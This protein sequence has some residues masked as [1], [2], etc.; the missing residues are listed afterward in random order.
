M[1]WD[2]YEGSSGANLEDLGWYG[3]SGMAIGGMG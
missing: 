3:R 2:G 1:C